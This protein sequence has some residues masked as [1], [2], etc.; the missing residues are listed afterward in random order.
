MKIT[1]TRNELVR[2]AAD[3]LNI[4]GTGQSLEADYAA[5]ID[6]NVDPLLMQLASDGIAEVVNDQSIPSEW[7]DSLAGLLAN[8]CAP[9]GGKNF[10]PQIKMF[11]EGMLR[12]V[13]SL[14]P[15]YNVAE[16]E[17]F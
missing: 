12:R 8:V 4:V 17:Y 5:R 3:K 9:V 13:N 7:F 14:G 1:K 6:N 10:D 11:Y 2:E 15:S 16:A